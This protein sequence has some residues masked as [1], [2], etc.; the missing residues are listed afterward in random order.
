[1]EED[2]SPDEVELV[3]QGVDMGRGALTAFVR[4]AE[5]GSGDGGEREMVLPQDDRGDILCVLFPAVF[6]SSSP[7]ASLRCFAFCGD[8][9]TLGFVL[10][11][12]G[13]FFDSSSSSTCSLGL[14]RLE[15]FPDLL[16]LPVSDVSLKSS[17]LFL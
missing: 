2:L 14:K 3:T 1:M 16:F 12:K 15:L 17:P 13:V 10:L 6:F 4:L 8:S 7:L 11:Y 9:A 5:E